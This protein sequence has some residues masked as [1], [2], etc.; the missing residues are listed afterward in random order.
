M[1][2]AG[3]LAQYMAVNNQLSYVTQQ[4]MHWDNL[5]EAMSKKLSEQ[6]K[7]ATKWEDA[8]QA[9]WDAEGD[10]SKDIH[11]GQNYYVKGGK[12][13]P[14]Y[15]MERAARAYADKK[16]PKYD[17]DKLEEYTA[18]DM[19]YDTMSEMYNALYDELTAQ[20]DSTKEATSTE[21][22]DTHILS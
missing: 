7:Y 1:A 17:S 9:V 22:K 6:E 4:K 19:E 10:N 14:G 5:K 8:T 2:T 3:L 21:A 12:P 11:I 18:L 16:V 20:R 15:N 13:G